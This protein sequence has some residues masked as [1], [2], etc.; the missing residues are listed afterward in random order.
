MTDPETAPETPG[1]PGARHKRR[2]RKGASYGKTAKLGAIW[3][4]VRQV[5]RH[6]IGIPTSMIMARLLSPV[7]FGVAAA[8][9]FF[10]LMASRMTELG[11]NAA[12]VRVKVLKAEHNSS[13]FVVSL[14]LGVLAWLGL[15]A[16]GP[17]V[18]RFFNS[19]EVGQVLPVA[20]L[21][22]LYS[23]FSTV[24]SALLQRQMRFKATSLAD[25]LDT[26]TGA[27]FAIILAYMGYSFWSLVYSQLA[28]GLVNVATKMYLA[29]WRPSLGFSWPALRELCS[30]GL[31][32]QLKRGLEFGAQNLDNL[33]IG[34]LLSISALGLYDK[35]FMTAQR[36][37]QMLNL[38]PAVS[39]RIFAIIQ[40]DA[41][42]FRR[43]YQKV[44]LTV[45]VVGFPPLAVA[46]V[47]APQL[48]EVMYG[49]QWLPAVPAFQ[50]LCLATIVKL[51]S[52]HA[53]RANE[54]K[55]MIWQQVLQHIL[56]VV[57][58]VAGVWVGSSWGIWGAACGVLAARALL[59]VLIQDLLQR[60]IGAH[61]I[62]MLRPAVPGVAISTAA[63][64][65]V[66][67]TELLL[68]RAV[69]DLAAWQLLGVQAVV[70]TLTYGGLV[71]LSPFSDVRAL[72]RE[73]LSDFAPRLA[74]W[75]GPPP[76]AVDAAKQA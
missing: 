37:L 7:E 12:L 60:S 40:D 23:P 51:A 75:Y 1:E 62:E 46:M 30:F 45:G 26:L 34:R 55:G 33:L 65:V 52:A 35:A 76:A 32:I 59:A 58:I 67:A 56:Y 17:W 72:V 21:A 68:R 43:A 66:V 49:V 53:T 8:A 73:T 3:S 47:T 64:V 22:F 13:V 54:A 10:L 20:A 4:V 69:P 14:G 11:L 63:C 29:R 5:V 36:L 71:L 70:A 38:G 2:R 41:E 15:A 44:L 39:F 74:A 16:A 42:R 31:G 50:V 19:P 18:G 24:P 61:W 6:G 25:W 48:F 27:V 9:A 57:A 28:A